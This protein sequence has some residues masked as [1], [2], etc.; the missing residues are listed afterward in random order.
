MVILVLLGKKYQPRQ[1]GSINFDDQVNS[2]KWDVTMTHLYQI[3]S[4]WCRDK[5]QADIHASGSGFHSLLSCYVLLPNSPQL[6]VTISLK[7]S[8]TTSDRKSVV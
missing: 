6:N 1:C 2:T 7:K 4:S 3:K 5:G 8:K